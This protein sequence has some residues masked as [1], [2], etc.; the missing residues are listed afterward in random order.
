MC[1]CSLE[2]LWY[3]G[4]NQKR[5]VQQSEGGDC[6]L[7]FCISETPARVLCPSL[8]R[9]TEERYGAFGE[10]LEEGHE[11]DPRAGTPLL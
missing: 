3:P 9:P 11:G 1:A 5:G 4:F 2:S 10:G 7:L 6:S 8:G